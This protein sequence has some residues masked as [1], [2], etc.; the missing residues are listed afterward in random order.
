MVDPSW[1]PAFSISRALSS[2]LPA[3]AG[4]A[5]AYVGQETRESQ[6]VHHLQIWQLSAIPTPSGTPTFQHLTQVDLYLDAT[7]LLPAALTFNTHPDNN[8]LLDI[9]VE[10][11]F[12]D[13]RPVSGNSA[14]VGAGLSPS[15]SPSSPQIPFH[16]Q[17][18]L[19]NS[20]LLD[21]QFQTATL[22]SGLTA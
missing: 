9:P 11:R 13:Y 18:F 6:S 19:N 17:K 5:S 16:I 2:G 1:F 14:T 12:S 8:M 7:T 3:G 21:L 4:F 15:T 22:N 10:I 20:L